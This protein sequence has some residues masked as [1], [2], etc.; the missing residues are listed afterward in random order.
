MYDIANNTIHFGKAELLMGHY[1]ESSGPNYTAMCQKYSSRLNKSLVEETL[2]R[3]VKNYHLYGDP[4]PEI[5]LDCAAAN[6]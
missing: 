3:L 2:P 6:S 5:C 1:F 4:L